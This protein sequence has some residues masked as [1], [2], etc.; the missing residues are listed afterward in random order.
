LT[1]RTEGR[2]NDPAIA[3]L[4]FQVRRVNQPTTDV[5]VRCEERPL[6]RRWVHTVNDLLGA[7]R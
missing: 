2:T 5:P 3:C 7:E 4:R 1:G 6:L